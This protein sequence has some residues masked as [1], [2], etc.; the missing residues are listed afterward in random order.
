MS[1]Q[2]LFPESLVSSK[3]QEDLPE[4]FLFRPLERNDFNKGHLDVLADLAWMGTITEADWLG[5]FD[6]MNKLSGTYYVL[7]IVDKSTEK[8]VGTG[9]LFVEKKLYVSPF[10]PRSMRFAYV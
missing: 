3:S 6:L 8:V 2:Y 5:R 10:I 1:S 9:T 4:G 7:V